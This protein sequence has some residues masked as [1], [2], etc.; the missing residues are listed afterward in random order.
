MTNARADHGSDTS[1]SL[2]PEGFGLP[3][4]FQSLVFS[5]LRLFRFSNERV[6]DDCIPG[7]VK[8]NE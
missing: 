5:F 3:G 1:R 6:V 8:A 4:S 7:V 2:N